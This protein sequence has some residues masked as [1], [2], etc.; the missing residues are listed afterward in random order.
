MR[1][2]TEANLRLLEINQIEAK[3]AI[4]LKGLAGKER[5]EA[6]TTQRKKD[7][8]DEVG[9]DPQHNTSTIPRIA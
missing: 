5:K 9:G 6:K 4:F 7:G 1:S 2:A 8:E 3:A